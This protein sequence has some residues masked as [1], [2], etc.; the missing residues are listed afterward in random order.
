MWT[1]YQLYFDA[2]I[3]I[4]WHCDDDEITEISDFPEG[5][6]TIESH[7]KDTNKK[8]MSGL[9][10]ILLIVYIR[11]SNLMASSS[12][13]DKQFSHISKINHT[14]EIMNELG[15]FRREFRDRQDV[16]DEIQMSISLIKDELQNP[17]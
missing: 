2:N 15:I 10:T 17:I 3:G 6:Y 11:T 5:V 4:W 8:F 7:K 9:D 16:S 13:S 12:V 14:K 1:L